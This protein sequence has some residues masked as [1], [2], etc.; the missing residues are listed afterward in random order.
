MAKRIDIL[1]ICIR[2]LAESL[3]NLS[4]MWEISMRFRDMFRKIK[5]TYLAIVS[6]EK[7]TNYINMSLSVEWLC[8]S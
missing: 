7:L 1:K 4:A 3:T 5:L 6:Q 2:Q 8:K